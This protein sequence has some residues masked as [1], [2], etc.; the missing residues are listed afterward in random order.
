MFYSSGGGFYI[1]PQQHPMGWTNY[2]KVGNLTVT[3]KLIMPSS[4]NC[5]SMKNIYTIILKAL[6]YHLLCY[7][8]FLIFFHMYTLLHN[9]SYFFGIF[10]LKFSYSLHFNYS[11]THGIAP[12]SERDEYHFKPTIRNTGNLNSC[13]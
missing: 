5:N 3:L 12:G 6:V 1:T 10:F 9:Q 11:A 4:S 2:E 13:I 7:H 8:F